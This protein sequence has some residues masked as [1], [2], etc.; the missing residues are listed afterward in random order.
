[1]INTKSNAPSNAGHPLR[2]PHRPLTILSWLVI[3]VATGVLMIMAAEKPDV[4]DLQPSSGADPTLVIQGRLVL[5][6][7]AMAHGTGMA[8]FEEI[9]L[10]NSPD[11]RL[12]LAGLAAAIGGPEAG[13]EIVTQVQAG[14]T[15]SGLVPTEFQ[16]SAIDGLDRVFAG[17][18]SA[19]TLE[20]VRTQLGWFGELAILASQD[21][22]EGRQSRLERQFGEAITMMVVMVTGL[23]IFAGV[24][25]L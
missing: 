10:S 6:Q 22:G 11:R 13:H 17:T 20:S 1:M 3:V 21:G 8:A 18:A 5:A 16:A 24:G 15:A 14:L 9:D 2:G 19:A 7:E 4:A 25:V 23:L 12:R